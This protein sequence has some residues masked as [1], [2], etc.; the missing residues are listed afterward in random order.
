[1][2]ETVENKVDRAIFV[3]EMSGIL[4]TLEEMKN[5]H[6]LMQF[7]IPFYRTPV[8]LLRESTRL[9]PLGVLGKPF[10]EKSTR[11]EEIARMTLGSLAGLTFMWRMLDGSIDVSGAI[12]KTEGERDLFYRQHKQPYSI[13]IGD[14]WYSYQQLQPFSS[15]LFG[16]S[17]LGE[18]IKVFKERGN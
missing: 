18:M 14:N 2:L 16:F 10:K 12:P 1:M 15:T 3:E 5:K 11:M 7:I 4:K 8:N 6:P 17:Q 9:T 13:R